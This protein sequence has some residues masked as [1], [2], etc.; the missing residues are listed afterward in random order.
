MRK[1]P[2]WDEPIAE[3]DEANLPR[4]QPHFGVL[5]HVPL[6]PCPHNTPY[7]AGSVL[8]CMQC[9]A[10]GLDARL[11]ALPRPALVARR[12][13][14]TKAPVTAV[15]ITQRTYDNWTKT[16]GGRKFLAAAA[17]EIVPDPPRAARAGRARRT[18]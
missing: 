5:P 3:P 2:Y 15:R 11:A 9:H 18:A 16:E 14:A 8:C 6:G 4:L 1:R 10:S 12:K 7:R 13:V 17:V